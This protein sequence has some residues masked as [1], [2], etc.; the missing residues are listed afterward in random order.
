M[1][2]AYTLTWGIVMRKDAGVTL[3]EAMVVIAIVA[4]LAAIAIPNWLSWRTKAK[5]N[6][7]ST[8]LRGDMEMA[9]NRAIKENALVVIAFNTGTNS[10]QIFVDNGAGTPANANNY[11]LDAGEQIIKSQQLAPG[12]SLAISSGFAGNSTGFS[13]RGTAGK[14]GILLISSGGKQRQIILSSLGRITLQY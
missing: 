7:V 13:P 6:G 9:K 10:Y 1:L 12:V 8:N 11:T 2:F 14:T 4:V 3:M 5:I